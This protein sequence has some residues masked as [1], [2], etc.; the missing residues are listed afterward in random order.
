MSSKKADKF[1]WQAI[2]DQF[3]GQMELNYIHIITPFSTVLIYIALPVLPAN[4]MWYNII[5]IRY[6]LDIYKEE[7]NTEE[8]K[9]ISIIAYFI[10]P[11]IFWN[12]LD[13][14]S[15][16]HIIKLKFKKLFIMLLRHK[17]YCSGLIKKKKF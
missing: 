13:I 4:Y 6:C 8:V 7:T 12:G 17:F 10:D 5:N 9:I 3:S 11:T 14:L 15:F 1:V 16:V 2:W